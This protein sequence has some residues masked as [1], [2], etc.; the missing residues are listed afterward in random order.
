M[1]SPALTAARA[2]RPTLPSIRAVPELAAHL[3][4]L[5]VRREGKRESLS[6]LTATSTATT[7][8]SPH[9]AMSF[10]TA[11]SSGPFRSP[12]TATYDNDDEEEGEDEEEDTMMAPPSPPAELPLVA[13]TSPGAQEGRGE[14][15]KSSRLGRKLPNRKHHI[16]CAAA[17]PCPTCKARQRAA[18]VLATPAASRP[19]LNRTPP[20]PSPP[21]P[22]HV[23]TVSL[24]PSPPSPPAPRVRPLPLPGTKPLKH[25][26][27]RF[28]TSAPLSSSS[29]SMTFS[30]HPPL[31]VSSTSSRSER[32]RLPPPPPP[33]PMYA[34][35]SPPS[36]V[37]A[38][39]ASARHCLP[40][41]SRAPLPSP[42]SRPPLQPR[43]S[44]S[45]NLPA[46]PAPI[47]GTRPHLDL[48][49]RRS[50]GAQGGTS[51]VRTGC[52]GEKERVAGGRGWG[53]ERFGA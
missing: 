49:R 45:P 35:P 29:P 10:G 9:A 40:P 6:P 28:V 18:A 27:F 4:P 31:V 23:L 46:G 8:A 11:D 47:V 39:L 2:D 22:A 34:H 30:A 43:S 33:P 5:A 37:P 48:L 50:S 17:R 42:S 15:K 51:S 14:K 36:A 1:P 32:H 7:A 16:E 21:R 44:S 38:L 13:S 24:P 41:S 26:L 25:P 12:S 20:L 3:P 52:A 19:S 53:R